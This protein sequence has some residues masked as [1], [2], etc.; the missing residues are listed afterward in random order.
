MRIKFPSIFFAEQQNQIYPTPNPPDKRF[1]PQD[2]E[3]N[4]K[5]PQSEAVAAS[6]EDKVPQSEAVA[7]SV[8]EEASCELC[9]TVEDA[10]KW[11]DELAR[12]RFGKFFVET[13]L[14]QGMP[15]STCQS[16]NWV[17][18]RS[19]KQKDKKEGEKKEDEKKKKKEG[20][21][22]KDEKKVEFYLGKDYPSFYVPKL[23]A[24]DTVFERGH[25][26]VKAKSFRDGKKADGVAPIQLQVK[27]KKLADPGGLLRSRSGKTGKV[28][29]KTVKK[30]EK[31]RTNSD[32]SAYSVRLC[33]FPLY[34][35]LLSCY[36]QRGDRRQKVTEDV[37]ES[38]IEFSVEW[39]SKSNKLL[40]N[41]VGMIQREKNLIDEQA[42]AAKTQKEEAKTQKEEAIKQKKMQEEAEIEQKRHL[43][44]YLETRLEQLEKERVPAWRKRSPTEAEVSDLEDLAKNALALMKKLKTQM[45][46]NDVLSKFLEVLREVA[47]FG[48]VPAF[49]AV[50]CDL[51]YCP[52]I[53]SAVF[54]QTNGCL[55][56]KRAPK[57]KSYAG[58]LA[59]V[60][61]DVDTRKAIVF[62]LTC[63]EKDV[64]LVQICGRQPWKGPPLTEKVFL[65]DT[66]ELCP[67]SSPTC[68]VDVGRVIDGE[69][70][71]CCHPDLFSLWN[72]SITRKK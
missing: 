24:P 63:E 20:E 23:S 65:S 6:V 59:G 40:E 30:P 25:L 72:E 22:K 49:V 50:K 52:E 31:K 2:A 46:V 43:L 39:C 27:Q 19:G 37:F 71:L 55:Y 4:N 33:A 38:K 15:K 11:D 70:A 56:L 68:V 14:S 67:S 58:V 41:F 51:R 9:R 8:E 60:R 5:V 69:L 17:M 47:S 61:G 1:R 18:D 42:K 54:W 32:H 62:D 48:L 36:E 45:G 26:Y 21:K 13:L 64:V 34:L 16:S 7:A 12:T 53:G 35:D 10:L 29:K 44:I 66:L 3:K 57:R 28:E